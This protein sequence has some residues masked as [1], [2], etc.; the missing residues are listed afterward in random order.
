MP[1]SQM[2]SCFFHFKVCVEI[3]APRLFQ[4]IPDSNLKKETTALNMYQTKS[5]TSLH[6]EQPLR[7]W[8]N[9]E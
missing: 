4:R 1:K 9:G 8:N 2:N 6:S 3:T 5:S 7:I